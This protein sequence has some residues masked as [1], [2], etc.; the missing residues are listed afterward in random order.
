MKIGEREYLGALRSG[1]EILQRTLPYCTI[2]TGS[3]A[4]SSDASNSLET[5]GRHNHRSSTQRR[6]AIVRQCSAYDVRHPHTGSHC[7]ITLPAQAIHVKR[8]SPSTRP[9]QGGTPMVS[10]ME[11]RCGHMS[12]TDGAMVVA[13]VIFARRYQL[14]A[15]CAPK[16]I[17]C[18]LILSYRR[19]AS[20]TSCM[21]CSFRTR[22]CG[23]HPYLQFRESHSIAVQRCVSAPVADLGGAALRQTR[24]RRAVG[25]TW[26][27]A[28][29][30]DSR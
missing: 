6:S 23:I 5:S 19:K 26:P 9:A 21:A 11:S 15:G 27:R 24:E 7:N 2:C 29:S 12:T 14:R 3:G 16:H 13:A 18:C 28:D 1:R 10:S 22:S 30:S 17:S 25:G 20:I 8:P 4:T